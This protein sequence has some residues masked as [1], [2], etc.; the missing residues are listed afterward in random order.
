MRDDQSLAADF[1]VIFQFERFQRP[2]RHGLRGHLGEMD[3]DAGFGSG[4]L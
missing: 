3:D 2:C 4:A 1:F